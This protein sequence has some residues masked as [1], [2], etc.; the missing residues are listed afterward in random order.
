M[1]Q[2]P[3]SGS[4][5]GKKVLIVEDQGE[6]GL[7]L[8]L[9]LEEKNLE[10]DY[11]NSLLDADEY[12]QKNNPSIIILDNKLPDG[13]GVDFVSYVK[14]K[15]PGIRII[16]ISGYPSAKDV[17]LENGADLFFEKPFSLDDF[18]NAIDR[19]LQ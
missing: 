4:V 12:L 2:L 1:P 15:F 3:K 16:M 14:K 17:A 13:F 9:I 5:T 18:N 7:L 11:V 6:I 10:P 8:D 19:L